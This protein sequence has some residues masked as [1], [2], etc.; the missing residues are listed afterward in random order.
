MIAWALCRASFALDVE[1]GHADD[2]EI[3]RCCNHIGD[4]KACV[5]SQPSDKSGL[6]VV[7]KEAVEDRCHLPSD[8]SNM[9]ND[10]KTG[11]FYRLDPSLHRL[12]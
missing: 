8:S 5:H 3:R 2:V 9:R 10:T 12:H 11:R 7:V 1:V 6:V 4:D